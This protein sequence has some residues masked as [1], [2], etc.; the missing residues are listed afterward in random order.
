M[1]ASVFTLSQ[2][3]DKIVLILKKERNMDIRKIL[4]A[5][6]EYSGFFT[7]AEMDES[8]KRLAAEFPELAELSLAGRS[9]KGR[10]IYCLKIGSGSKNALFFASPHPNEPIGSTMLEFFSR[11]LCEHPDLLKELDH[12]F[13]IVK[14]VDPDGTALN[15]GWFKGPFTVYNYARNFF[16]PAG[17]MQTEWTFPIEIDDYKFDKPIPETQVLMKLIEEI[18]PAFMYSLHNAGFGGVYWYLGRDLPG[19]YPEFYKLIE[20]LEL[21]LNM[22]EPE[23]DYAPVYSHAV[24]GA[25]T[26]RQKVDYMAKMGMP[27]SKSMH[28]GCDSSEYAARFCDCFT[29]ITE[30]PYFFDPRVADVGE[31]SMKRETAALRKLEIQAELGKF[32]GEQFGKV[33][34]LMSPGNTLA[35]AVSM[36]G[37][38]NPERDEAR[39]KMMAS[40]PDYQRI[41]NNAEVFDNLCGS[42]FYKMLGVGILARACRWELDKEG[43]TEEAR[44]RLIEVEEAAS[45]MLRKQCEIFES[46]VPYSVVPVKKLVAA[47][48]GSGLI[49]MSKLK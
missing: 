40:S 21:P 33:E 13:Y 12:T 10:P 29:I 4:D 17:H 3:C 7:M 39:R 46:E 47:Q 8:S 22:G 11:Y 42:R 34:D 15:E 6:P 44:L 16:R 31:S 48:L 27:A 14:S 2:F 24:Y 30:A 32:I 35:V 43:L 25:S 26:S 23:I 5:I 36:Y 20:D 37:K 38:V 28:G 18:K 49:A 45:D 19:A 41:A 1:G 9:R